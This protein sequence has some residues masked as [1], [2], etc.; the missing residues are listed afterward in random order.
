MHARRNG[1]QKRGCSPL[2]TSTWPEEGKLEHFGA[3]LPWLMS[4]LVL[5]QNA[6]A[7]GR[8]SRRA[9]ALAASRGVKQGRG[10]R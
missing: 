4:K 3:F 6:I 9:G 2:Q 5:N 7:Q 1:S 8:S 10:P